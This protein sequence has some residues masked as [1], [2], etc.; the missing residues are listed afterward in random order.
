MGK[1]SPIGSVNFALVRHEMTT[2][3]KLEVPATHAPI[4]WPGSNMG[5]LSGSSFASVSNTAGARYSPA[6]SGI[7]PDKSRMDSSAAKTAGFS[8]PSAPTLRNRGMS[9]I[10]SS[11][12]TKSLVNFPGRRTSMPCLIN[13]SPEKFP[14]CIEPSS[15]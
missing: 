5:S 14:A 3:M 1:D 8:V 12:Y 4:R 13:A 7:W 10:A 2:A 6:K 9:Y 15:P 11:M